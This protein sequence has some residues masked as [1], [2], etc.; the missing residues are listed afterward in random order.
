M[1]GQAHF[2]IVLPPILVLCAIVSFI[3]KSAIAV[4]SRRFRINFVPVDGFQAEL[5]AVGYFGVAIS[6]FAYGSARLDARMSG[7]YEYLLAAGLII[8]L[9]G[10]GWGNLIFYTG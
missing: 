3:E 9:V 1:V 10:L 2:G 8:A 5:M 4:E 7:W 6:L